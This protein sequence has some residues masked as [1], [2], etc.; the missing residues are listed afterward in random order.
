MPAPKVH[1]PWQL[2]QKEQSDYKVG[3]KVMP[4]QHLVVPSHHAETF[5]SV[6]KNQ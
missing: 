4:S 3:G 6:P 5:S 1:T 2:S